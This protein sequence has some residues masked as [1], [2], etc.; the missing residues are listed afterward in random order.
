[1][2]WTLV[3]KVAL[4][5]GLFYMVDLF[6]QWKGRKLER[7]RVERLLDRALQVRYSGSI[8]WVWNAVSSGSKILM[9]EDKFFGPK[10]EDT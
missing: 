4:L 6:G 3:L 9:D 5:A 7:E 2:D 1:M 8:R 10:K